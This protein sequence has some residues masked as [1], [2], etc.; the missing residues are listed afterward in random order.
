MT[1]AYPLGITLDDSSQTSQDALNV[2]EKFYS[3]YDIKKELINRSEKSYKEKDLIAGCDGDKDCLKYANRIIEL[4]NLKF[5]Y[6]LGKENIE[7]LIT[8]GVEYLK[9]NP[10]LDL[11]EM[12]YELESIGGRY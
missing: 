2:W 10:D 3:R 4:H 6:T 12:I 9:Q 5:I 7:P 8:K 1:F 11:N